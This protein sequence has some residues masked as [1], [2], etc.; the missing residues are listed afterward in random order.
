MGAGPHVG[1]HSCPHT[2]TS[3]R[4]PAQSVTR[5]EM[6]GCLTRARFPS[7]AF[8]HNLPGSELNLLKTTNSQDVYFF[9]CIILY[10]AERIYKMSES[11]SS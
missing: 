1:T 9:V 2:D 7:L 8:M 5:M 10:M 4:S 6:N 11:L 3:S